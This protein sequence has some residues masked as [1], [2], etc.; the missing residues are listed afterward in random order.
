MLMSSGDIWINSYL[1]ELNPNLDLSMLEDYIAW[2]SK[3][4]SYCFKVAPPKPWQ[5]KILDA[6]RECEH[7]CEM[8]VNKCLVNFY[9]YPLLG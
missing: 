9:I 4:V 6:L 8:A 5:G 1:Y 2:D 7:D 3:L